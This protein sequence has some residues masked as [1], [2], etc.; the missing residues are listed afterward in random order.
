MAGHLARRPELA[1]EPADGVSFQGVEREA[2]LVGAM[3][4]AA[5][6]DTLLNSPFARRDASQ[7]HPAFAGGAH[8]PLN[9]GITHYPPPRRKGYALVEMPVCP[10]ADSSAKFCRG[11]ADEQRTIPSGSVEPDRQR[12]L[13]VAVAAFVAVDEI[14]KEERNVALLQIAAL[15]QFLGDVA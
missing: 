11:A 8:R 12:Q 9:N 15:A 1:G 5:L 14:L 6:E 4:S 13:D 3:A 2:D 10:V 7:S